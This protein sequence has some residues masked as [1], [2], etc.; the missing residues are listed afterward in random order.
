[1]I[2]VQ[3]SKKTKGESDL[4]VGG[5]FGGQKGQSSPHPTRSLIL[6]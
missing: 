3:A 4:Q 6:V 2:Q 1:M 5:P